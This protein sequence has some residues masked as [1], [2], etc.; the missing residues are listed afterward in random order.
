M[1]GHPAELEAGLDA[2]R[3]GQADW[4]SLC[5]KLRY[6]RNMRWLADLYACRWCMPEATTE[7]LWIDSWDD[8]EEAELIAAAWGLPPPRRDWGGSVKVRG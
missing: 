8:D 7:A 5:D 4:C 6:R 2:A 1:A 3:N